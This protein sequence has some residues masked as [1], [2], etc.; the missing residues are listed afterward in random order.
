MASPSKAH[1][2]SSQEGAK[3]RLLKESRK[4]KREADEEIEERHR[5]ERQREQLDAEAAR[6]RKY[7]Q[8]AEEE[9]PAKAKVAKRKGVKSKID[10]EKEKEIIEMAGLEAEE[11]K[12]AMLEAYN[13]DVDAIKAKRPAI[14]KLMAARDLY[15]KL[16]KRETE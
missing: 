1:N 6:V 16:K 15:Q 11:I 10:P 14:S 13:N 3:K 5:L 4:H 9:D 7:K 12:N 2:K 8:K